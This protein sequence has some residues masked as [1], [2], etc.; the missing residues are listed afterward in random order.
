LP[1]RYTR[2]SLAGRICN[3]ALLDGECTFHHPFQLKCCRKEILP[4]LV[5]PPPN[6][7]QVLHLHHKFFIQVCIFT[8]PSQLYARPISIT[9]VL[10][11]W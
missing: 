9:D 3:L 4:K 11:N 5:G 8:P 2:F 1:C 7:I 10:P 6:F